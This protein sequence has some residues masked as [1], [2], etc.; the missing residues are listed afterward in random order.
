MEYRLRLVCHDL[1][2]G[3]KRYEVLQ[4]FYKAETLL[5]PDDPCM[6]HKSFAVLDWRSVFT[7]SLPECEA[8]ISLSMKGIYIEE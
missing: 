6:K 3:E 7:G 4:Y 1:S 8:W 2:S 5:I